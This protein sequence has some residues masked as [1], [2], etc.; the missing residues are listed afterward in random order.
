MG[1]IDWADVL[2]GALAFFLVVVGIGIAYV[3]VRLGALLNRMARTVGQMT[4]EVVPILN[5][6]QTTVDG[7]NL[8]LVRVDDIMVS[9]VNATKGAEKTVTSISG[10]VTAPVRKASG[11]AA[12]AKEAFATFR[13]RRTA[14]PNEAEAAIDGVDGPEAIAATRADGADEP[15]IPASA[16]T[17]AAE[18]F[19]DAAGQG[20]TRF[21]EA[22]ATA[23]ARRDDDVFARH[24][25]PPAAPGP[26]VDEQPTAPIP[27]IE[28]RDDDSGPASGNGGR[29]RGPSR[30]QIEW[31]LVKR[32]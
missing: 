32:P 23:V 22:M 13:T 2:R 10:A 26:V 5:R 11:L 16:T 24:V 12:A 8:E 17:R 30:S 20:A 3:C 7:I 31:A 18:V 6:A 27:R 29:R 4:D 15:Q 19:R 9:A 21:K 1:S 28:S 14:G 25:R